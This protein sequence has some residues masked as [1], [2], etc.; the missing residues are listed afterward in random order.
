ML[1]DVGLLVARLITGGT[2]VSHGYPKLFGGPGARTPDVMTRVYGPQ[3]PGAVEA[4]G[5]EA[6]ARVLEQL[7]IPNPRAAAYLSGAAELGGGLL[8]MLGLR[9]RLAALVV[10]A[11]MLV[12]IR[13]VHWEKGFSGPGGHEL[14]TQIAGSA[15]ALLCT[16]AGALSL[17]GLMAGARHT[18]AAA[19]GAAE[20]ARSLA[21]HD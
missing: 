19:G 7:G 8:L 4:G 20:R 11:N 2:L 6:F 15:A 17:D 18:R 3:Y 16:G 5:P 10:L 1:K 13:K 14:A 9:T 12:A 21:H